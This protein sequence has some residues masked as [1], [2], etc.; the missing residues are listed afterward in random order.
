VIT[1]DLSNPGSLEKILSSL[2]GENSA[3]HLD[4]ALVHIDVSTYK[5]THHT[6]EEIHPYLNIHGS[7]VLERG[8][9]IDGVGHAINEFLSENQGDF[10]FVGEECDTIWIAPK[11]GYGWTD[12]RVSTF[13]EYL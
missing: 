7:V 5:P 9:G 4:F 2:K 3:N 8:I 1:I 11:K 12:S 10:R 13:P 6:L